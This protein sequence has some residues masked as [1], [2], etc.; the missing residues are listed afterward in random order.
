LEFQINSIHLISDFIPQFLHTILM[1]IYESLYQ[2]ISYLPEEKIILQ[3]WFESSQ[4]MTD[5]IYRIE[6]TSLIDTVNQTKPLRALV[7]AQKFLFVIS[8]NLQEW[9]NVHVNIPIISS[10]L[11]KSAF[12]MPSEF[13]AHLSVEQV[14]DDIEP[15]VRNI[16]YFSDQEEAMQWI[17]S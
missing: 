15:S 12:V 16:R 2:Q 10:N 3:H 14:F 8:P 11:E 7:Q 1:I 6:M 9:T 5:E 17:L 13:I 4:E